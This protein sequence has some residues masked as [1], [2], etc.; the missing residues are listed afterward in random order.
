[1][2]RGPDAQ[3]SVKGAR[4]WRASRSDGEAAL[5]PHL[6]AR[7]EA[8]QALQGEPRPC[9]VLAPASA[10]LRE[11]NA[12]A[13]AGVGVYKSDAAL[14]QDL[15]NA[16]ERAGLH[17]ANSG[18]KSLDRGGGN[19]CRGGELSNAQTKRCTGQP[20]LHWRQHLGLRNKNFIRGI[21]SVESVCEV[22]R[23]LS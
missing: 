13:A 9:P 12:G 20:Y 7:Q 11:A 14:F 3:A 1:M 22:L 16:V 15:L 6:T 21:D 18:L 2:E 17:S 10:L 23:T 5:A 19:L 4:R 8:L